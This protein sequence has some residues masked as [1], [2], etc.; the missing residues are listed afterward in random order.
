MYVCRPYGCFKTECHFRVL[1]TNKYN[2]YKASYSHRKGQ[3]LSDTFYF[4][5]QNHLAIRNQGIKNYRHDLRRD[6][7]KQLHCT[8]L[9]KRNYRTRLS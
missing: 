8:E 9:D 5:L 2:W 4:D 1:N 6:V 7:S 3:V